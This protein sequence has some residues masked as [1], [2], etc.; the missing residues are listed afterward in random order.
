MPSYH[1]M[2]RNS[3]R[4]G[5]QHW[6]YQ[7]CTQRVKTSKSYSFGINFNKKNLVSFKCLKKSQCDE[8][9]YSC[10][11]CIETRSLSAIQT[12]LFYELGLMKSPLDM[13][14]MNG[15]FLLQYVAFT[16]FSPNLKFHF[17][18]QLT[19]EISSLL[20]RS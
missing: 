4:A 19:P 18:S 16:F 20:P 1:Y 14:I 6:P 11:Q 3:N 10:P 8:L 5:C 2:M 13:I 9:M 12:P 17:I 7:H 15:W